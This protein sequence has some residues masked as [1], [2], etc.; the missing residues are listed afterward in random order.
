MN[1]VEKIFKKFA[2]LDLENYYLLDK[3]NAIEFIIQCKIKNISILGI[4]GF[5]QINNIIQPIQESSID[6]STISVINNLLSK[7][8]IYEKSIQFLESQDENICF[9]IICND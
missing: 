6:F 1:E 3:Y 4:D 5:I 2:V 9:E 7:E 8:N